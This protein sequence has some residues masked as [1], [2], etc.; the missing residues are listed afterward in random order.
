MKDAVDATGVGIARLAVKNRLFA[1]FDTFLPPLGG[2]ATEAREQPLR[3]YILC[4]LHNPWFILCT[5]SYR[6]RYH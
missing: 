1:P 2:S 3:L 4:R 5:Q 6:G